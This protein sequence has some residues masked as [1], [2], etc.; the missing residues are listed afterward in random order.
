M[1]VEIL[2]HGSVSL[3]FSDHL[4]LVNT[5]MFPIFTST[6]LGTQ[7]SDRSSYINS[8]IVSLGFSWFFGKEVK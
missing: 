3:K 6:T 1:E 4:S 5:N 2:K 8:A 7:N